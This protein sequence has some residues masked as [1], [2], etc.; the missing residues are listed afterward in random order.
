MLIRQ[1]FTLE[2]EKRSRPQAEGIAENIM[3]VQDEMRQVAAEILG[4]HNPLARQVDLD[5]YIAQ[6]RQKISKKYQL[7]EDTTE[8][9]LEGEDDDESSIY[10]ASDIPNEISKVRDLLQIIPGTR[11]RKFDTLLRAIDG[12]RA[13]HPEERF[14]IFTQ[15]RE[16]LEFLR[17]ELE[18]IFGKAR[19]VTI[20]GGPLAD[21]L[22]AVEKI[23]A[24][25][26]A[27]FLVSTSAGG[28]GINLQVAHILFN[29]DLP[30]NPMAVEQR[31]G[32]VHRFGQ[33]DTVQVYNLVAEDTV[34][35]QIYH[36]LESK[37]KEIA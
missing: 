19:V 4:I 7:D 17:E 27:Q 26:G 34:E 31:I 36:I 23:W 21:K 22:E 8:W 15:Y 3:R 14:I 1:H 28:E 13:D 16:T 35:A 12:I 29:Y 30:W 11:D 9:A 25:N 33:Y 18:Q 32:R 5:A 2:V 37:L 20:K 6:M 24:E 10:A